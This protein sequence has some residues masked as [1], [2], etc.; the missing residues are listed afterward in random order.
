LASSISR[1]WSWS[2]IDAFA[3]ALRAGVTEEEWTKLG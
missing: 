3:G 1:V 2:M